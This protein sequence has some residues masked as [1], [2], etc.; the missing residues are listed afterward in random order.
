MIIDC[1]YRKHEIAVRVAYF[2]CTATVT[3]AF[4]GLLAFAISHMDGV[5][6]LSG[7]S[8]QS[9]FSLVFFNLV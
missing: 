1:R 2:F 5:S 4:S 9:H 6:G 7:V 3:G 8:I